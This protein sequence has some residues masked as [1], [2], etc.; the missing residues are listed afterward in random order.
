MLAHER[1][2][3]GHG[4]G[5]AAER[6]LGFEPQL[7]RGQ[8]QLLEP[9]GLVA[10]EGVVAEVGQRRPAPERERLAAS[11]S[12]ACSASPS[13]SSRRARPSSSSNVSRSSVPA[14]DAKRVARRPRLDHTRAERL[15]QLR[16]VHL[17]RLDRRRRRPLAPE[18]ADDRRGRDE[19]AP[20][21][22]QQREHRP[23]PR[24]AH[25]QL[26][27][28]LPHRERAQNPE[29]HLPKVTPARAGPFTGVCR[30]LPR[31]FT[32]ATSPSPSDRN[33]DR[34]RREGA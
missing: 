28:V 31:L 27:A 3:L 2:E 15:A 16:D 9:R 5:V 29:L 20:A 10:R 19:L 33:G 18:Q 1:L 7:D 6:E 25:R 13:P 30:M 11:T 24:R 17:N 26:P 34:R 12:A 32:A 21:Q 14:L 8:A 22:Q 4:L 23:L